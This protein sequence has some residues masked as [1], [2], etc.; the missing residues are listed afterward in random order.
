MKKIAVVLLFLFSFYYFAQAQKV[1]NNR[2]EKQTFVYSIKGSDTLLLDK[3]DLPDLKNEK[4]C[5]IFMFGGGFMSGKRNSD[6]YIPY[7][8]HLCRIGYTVVSIDYR[9]GLKGVKATDGANPMRLVAM[10]NNSIQIAVEDLFDATHF[11][12]NHAKEWNIDKNMIVANG[13][14][15]GAISVLHGEY[16]ICNKDKVT[17]KLPKDFRYAG[18][19]AFAG[20]IFSANGDLKWQLPPSP[21]Q[22]FHGDADSNVPFDK[23]VID[24]Y[25][26][27]GSKHIAGQLDNLQSP[28][29][30]YQVENA[31]HEISGTPMKS[32]LNEIKS[33]LNKFIKEKQPLIIDTQT[34]EIGKPDRK[35]D[36]ELLDY[37]KSNFG[38]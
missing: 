21:I 5:I 36:F 6:N 4:S 17:E 35:K 30:F 16:A 24:K 19:I 13:S 38:S 22:L 9:L 11:I 37:I 12:V 18:I 26:F 7:F 31:A 33:F 1:D 34:K 23:I 15:A 10:L 27:Y 20:A 8:D 3:Y 29:Y 28:Y 32:N 2:I 25:G 14:S